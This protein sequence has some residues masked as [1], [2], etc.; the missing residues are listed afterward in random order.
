M[1]IDS[2]SIEALSRLLAA[3]AE[4]QRGVHPHFYGVTMLN[5]AVN[6]MMSGS[7]EIGCAYAQEAIEALGGTSSRIELSAALVA[8]AQ[9]LTFWASSIRRSRRLV[10]RCELDETEAN[11]EHA[12]LADCF[13]NPTPPER[14]SMHSRITGKQHAPLLLRAPRRHGSGAA[15]AVSTRQPRPI[16]MPTTFEGVFLGV[17]TGATQRPPPTSRLLRAP[18]KVESRDRCASTS[19][20]QQGRNEVDADRRTTDGVLRIASEFGSVITNVGADCALECD[21]CRGPGSSAAR[22]T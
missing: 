2:G 3:M 21:V 6:T 10:G 9:S 20:R 15:R 7:T 11:L 4:R 14:S 1:P 18:I 12:D 5:L 13:T 8:L 16:A 17:A 19:A 22:R